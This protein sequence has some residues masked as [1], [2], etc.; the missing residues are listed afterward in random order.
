MRTVLRLGD[1]RGARVIL[2]SRRR[3]LNPAAAFSCLWTVAQQAHVN[4]QQA[5]KSALWV[6]CGY[7]ADN[8]GVGLYAAL[9]SFPM[10][11]TATAK[12]GGLSSF[13]AMGG[14][15]AEPGRGNLAAHRCSNL[16]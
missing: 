7:A 15:G 10:C 9:S 6:R 5:E 8:E 3:C 16:L 11:S 14:S 12:L 2:E 4:P 13:K 1:L